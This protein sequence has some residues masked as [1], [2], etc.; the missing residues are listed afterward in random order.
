MPVNCRLIDVADST[1]LCSIL[2]SYALELPHKIT[3][4]PVRI[5]S[6]VHLQTFVR[7]FGDMLNLF[8]L[9][10]FKIW[11]FFDNV[12]AGDKSNQVNNWYLDSCKQVWNEMFYQHLSLSYVLCYQN[13]PIFPLFQCCARNSKKPS[14]ATAV[15]YKRTETTGNTQ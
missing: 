1:A 10:Y 8:K 13:Q 2:H 7:V 14:K 6:T 5:L 12:K 3:V 11:Q 9:P 4:Q 15:S